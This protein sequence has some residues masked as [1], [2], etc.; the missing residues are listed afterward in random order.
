M[1]TYMRCRECQYYYLIGYR[2]TIPSRDDSYVCE[3]CVH[4]VIDCLEEQGID[5]QLSRI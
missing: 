4:Y 2:I 3:L 5:Y 1:L